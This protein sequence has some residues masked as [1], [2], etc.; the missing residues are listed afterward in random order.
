MGTSVYI[1]IKGSEA[2][3]ADPWKNETKVPRRRNVE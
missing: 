2:L 3:K 1:R